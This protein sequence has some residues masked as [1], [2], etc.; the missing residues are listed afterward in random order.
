VKT[1]VLSGKGG[2]GKTFVSVNL[3][4][5]AGKSMYIDCDVEEPNGHIF[6]K[7]TVDGTES[8]C[9][10]IPKVNQSKCSG[11]RK[12]VDFCR[13]N[14]LA[15][16]R[17]RV[18]VFEDICHS[19]GGCSLVCPEGAITEKPKEIG[20]IKSGNSGDVRVISGIMDTGE[21]SGVP[22][23]KQLLEKTWEETD[24][25]IDAPPGSACTVMESIR[26]IDYCILVTEPT[27][28]GLH[29][30]KMVLELVDIFKKPHGVVI[31]K[32]VG[33]FPVLENYLKS[34]NTEILMEIKYDPVLGDLNSRGMIAAKEN[35]RYHDMFTELLSGIEGKAAHV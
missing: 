21:E 12:C 32:T 19:C 17:D 24:V 18:E 7:P 28:F 22:I 4:Y 13:F 11:C 6:L 1:A 30:L 5:A 27:V 35:P 10:L 26:D 29:N 34:R 8:V 3:A 16:I 31:N 2:T 20:V 33:P 14:A 25:F 23:I 9:V 15:Y